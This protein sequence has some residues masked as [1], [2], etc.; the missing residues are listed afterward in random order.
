LDALSDGAERLFWRLTTVADDWGR[1]DADPR[2]LLANCF[3]LRVHRLPVRRI[4]SWRDELV[5]AEILHLYTVND[6][7]YGVFIHWFDHQRQ[8]STRPKYPAPEDGTPYSAAIRGDSP[9]SAATRGLGY[10][11]VGME[12][13]EGGMGD[14]AAQPPARPQ[15]AADDLVALWNEIMAKPKVSKLG[16]SERLRY[17]IARLRENADPAWWRAV[18]ER[19]A[20]SSFLTGGGPRGWRADFDWLV[21]N[22]WNA[23]KVAEG[24]YDDATVGDRANQMLHELRNG[25][26]VEKTG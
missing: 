22:D 26:T 23:V 4:E 2:V 1:F 16:H 18:I 3:P 20:R 19:I 7:I 15:L 17:V 13:R 9:Q 21:Q 6:R 12:S 10:G 14:G 11:A 24:K 8:R 5:T 25:A